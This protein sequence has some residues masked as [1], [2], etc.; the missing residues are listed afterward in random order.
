MCFCC[1]GCL[2]YK[3]QIVL[4]LFLK[5]YT[6]LQS[7]ERKYKV[8]MDK[9]MPHYPDTSQLAIIGKSMADKLLAMGEAPISLD[10]V[11]LRLQARDAASHE[12]YMAATSE[13]HSYISGHGH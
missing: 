8:Y 11:L 1:F 12:R 3:Y 6:L 2:V 13:V 7:V 5:F 4:N 10:D 9:L